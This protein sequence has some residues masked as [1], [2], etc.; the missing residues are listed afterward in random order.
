M[1]LI[2]SKCAICNGKI[3][4]IYDIPNIPVNLSCIDSTDNMQYDNLSFSQCC[5]CNTIQLDTLI[6][7]YILYQSSHNDVSVGKTWENYFHL[8]IGKLTGIIENKTVLEIGCPSGKMAKKMENYKNWIIVDP[9]IRTTS[10]FNDRVEIVPSFFDC[11][12][13]IDRQIDVIVHSHLF[14]HIYDPNT[15]LQKCYALLEDEGEMIFGVPNMEYLSNISLFLGIFFE[16][17]IFLNKTNIAYLLNKNRF[18][19]VNIVDYE[20]H[21]TIYHVKKVNVIDSYEKQVCKITNYYDQF[22]TMNAILLQ[23]IDMCNRIIAENKNATIYIFGA[24]YNTQFILKMGIDES[25]LSGILDNCKKKQGKYLYGSKLK[26][27]SPDTIVGK[28]NVVVILRNGYYSQEI[29]EQ[30]IQLNANAII[31]K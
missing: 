17:T 3:T 31:C 23:Y 13:Q 20:S 10:E 16:H 4:H 6:S 27:Q 14:E 29:Y 21:S 8:F 25:L 1:N 2:R 15:F 28:S 9:N 30:L 11:D 12:F 26:I 22:F 5:D 19:I 24:S 7:P 18:N